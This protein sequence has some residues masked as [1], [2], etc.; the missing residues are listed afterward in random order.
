MRVLTT[1]PACGA[2]G[3]GKLTADRA[4]T[5]LF[6]AVA[7]Q[8]GMA[9]VVPHPRMRDAPPMYITPARKHFPQSAALGVGNL[10]RVHVSGFNKT[11]PA[12]PLS[13]KASNAAVAQMRGPVRAARGESVGD[14]LRAVRR[15]V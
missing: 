9:V 4:V 10:V 3:R 8:F 12:D 1:C 14:A 15:E 7:L 2:S 5:L 11:R 6:L 13:G